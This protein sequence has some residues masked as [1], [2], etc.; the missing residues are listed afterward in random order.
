MKVKQ[1]GTEDEWCI[2]KPVVCADG[3]RVSIQASKGHY[4]WPRDN[5]RAYKACELGYPSEPDDLIKEYAE[6]RLG[7][8]NYVDCVYP[9]VPA[10]VIQALLE[11]HGGIVSGECPQ[12]DL[13]ESEEE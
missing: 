4:S 13:T 7:E 9:F 5:V 3:F 12:L 6:Q 10:K 8:N 2:R 1:E 11:K